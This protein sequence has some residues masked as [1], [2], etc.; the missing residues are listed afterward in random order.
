MGKTKPV[1][2]IGIHGTLYKKSFTL[3]VDSLWG[4]C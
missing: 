3:G 1:F 2:P 4:L